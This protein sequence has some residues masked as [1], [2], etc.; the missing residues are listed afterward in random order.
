M[1]HT[2]HLSGVAIAGALLAV[3]AMAGPASAAPASADSAAHTGGGAAHTG[4][5]AACGGTGP[6]TAPAGTLHDGGA[7]DRP[8][9][10]R[11]GDGAP[12]RLGH[13][14][15]GPAA[16]QPAAGARDPRTP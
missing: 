12:V 4:G 9:P 5:G 3:A 2:R 10:P 6:A 15:R 16:S 1:R 14:I 11:G 7:D 13:R 8:G